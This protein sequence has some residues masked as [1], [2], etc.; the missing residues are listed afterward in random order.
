MLCLASSCIIDPIDGFMTDSDQGYI[1]LGFFNVNNSN[2]FFSHPHC[3]EAIAA[4]V[5]TWQDSCTCVV[6]VKISRNRMAQNWII[7]TYYFYCILIDS[8]K[9]WQWEVSQDFLPDVTSTVDQI[10]GLVQDC[11][12][13][14]ALAMELLQSCTKPLKLS[15][16]IH[17]SVTSSVAQFKT[18]VIPVHWQ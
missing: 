11:S 2:W 13:S 8:H 7:A 6:H 17:P 9:Q 4:K 1:S 5:C 14:S 15:L 16:D 3:D 10:D 12:N 18:A